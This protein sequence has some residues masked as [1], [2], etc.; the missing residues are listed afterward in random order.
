VTLT[1]SIATPVMA[2]RVDIFALSRV[3]IAA[4]AAV[5]FAAMISAMTFILPP[6]T[7]NCM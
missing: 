2:L 1:F 7:D 5:A 3:L 4:S 6:V